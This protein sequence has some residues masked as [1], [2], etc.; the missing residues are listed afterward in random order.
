MSSDRNALRVG[1]VTMGLA[2]AFFGAL[3]YISSNKAQENEV[4]FKNISQSEQETLRKY[5]QNGNHILETNES[6]NLFKDYM[7]VPR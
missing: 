3:V 2:S 5:D 7:L 4:S 6:V 1:A